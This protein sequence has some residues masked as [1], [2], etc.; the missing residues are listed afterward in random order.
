VQKTSA[1]FPRAEPY[2]IPFRPFVNAY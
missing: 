1:H 2:Y